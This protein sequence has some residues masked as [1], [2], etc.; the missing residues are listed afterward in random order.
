MRSKILKV[1]SFG[2]LAAV[3]VM[4]MAATVIEKLHGTSA[5]FRAVYHSPVFIALWAV[6]AGAGLVWLLRSGAAKRRATLCLHLALI[7]ILVG[8]LVTHL[9]GEQGR[10]HLRMR[11]TVDSFVLADGRVRPFDGF[12]IWLRDFRVEYYEGSAQASDYV[13]E[14]MIEDVDEILESA[15][16]SMNRIFRWRG[17]RFYQLSYDEDMQGS[18]L[19]VYHD[20]WGVGITY[21]GYLLLLLSMI[22]FFF[23]KDSGFHQVLRR[24]RTAA[25]LLLLL[26]LPQRGLAAGAELPPALPAEVA[27]QFGELYVYHNDRI[28][29]MQTLAR[30][31]CLKAYG[32]AHYG[33]YSAE[34]VVTGWLFY[35]DWWRAEPFKLKA[36]EA[37]T[38]KE[39]EKEAIRMSAA[40]GRAFKIFPI[41]FADSLVAANPGLRP[42]V[43]FHCDEPLP[44]GLDYERWVFIRR[45]LD[46]LHDEIRAENWPEVSRLLAKI[47]QYQEKEAGAVLPSARKI[48]AERFYNRISRPM[49][50]FMASITLGILVFVLS[51]ILMA[52]GRQTPR[53]LQR[54]LAGV[55]LLLFCYLTVVL[56]L[57]WYVSGHAPFAGSYSVMLLMAWVSALA[58]LL[59]WRRFA[60]VQPLGLV[61]AGFTM[62]LASLASANP[63]ITHL[64]PVLQSPLLSI[65]VLSMMVSYTLFGLVALNGVMGVFLPAAPSERLRDVSLLI[66]YP[67][68]FLLTFGTFLGA[69]WANISWGSYWSWDPKETWALV[70]L[71]IYASGLHGA[72]IPAFRRPR[73]FHVFSILAFLA[74][75]VTYFGVNLF[76]GGMHSYS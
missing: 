35:Y 52:R 42:V 50:P 59:L 36:G 41:A 44:E 15:T 64:M 29:P 47:R 51:G 48:R 7:V 32:K 38:E 73:F 71:L 21:A 74:V 31:Y 23:Q 54:V 66:L 11:E 25:P 37:G 14:L 55:A 8:A 12:N 43:W 17:Y 68:V 58:M 24:V 34:Q 16:V 4:M 72:S 69:V 18:W 65:H 61:L 30:D 33:P 20:P 13:S 76:L 63:Q 56:G 9:T 75:L 26:L 19:S 39:R 49:V 45:S 10:V 53:W 5:A 46:L 57:R 28:A 60:L 6:A 40:S 3:I 22:A 70:T 2:S 1:L 62:L 67:A 27:E